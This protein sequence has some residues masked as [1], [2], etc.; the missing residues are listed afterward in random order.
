MDK[1]VK[2]YYK[3]YA[4]YDNYAS[5]PCNIDGLKPVERRIL[6]ASLKVASAK[7]TKSAK[8]DGYTIGNYHPH[9]SCYTTIVEM[10]NQGFFHKQGEFGLNIGVEKTAPAAMR[11][12]E[13]KLKKWIK[14]FCFKYKDM[15]QWKKNELEE[16]E[17][18]YLPVPIPMCF[19]GKNLTYGIGTGY[20]TLIPAFKIN[21]LIQRLKWL[22]DKN[23][24]KKNEPIIKPR[25]DCEVVSSKKDLKKLL[26]TGE[27]RLSLKGKYSKFPS[28]NSIVIYSYPTGKKFQSIYQSYFSEEIKNNNISFLDLSSDGQTK[29]EISVTKTRNKSEIFKN[30]VSKMDDMLS[31][32]INFKI[33]VNDYETKKPVVQSVDEMLLNTYLTFKK[34]NEKMLNM[35]IQKIDESIE[36]LNK[37]ALIRPSLSEVLKKDWDLEKS[38]KYIAKKHKLEFDEVSSIINRYRIAKLLTL[39]TDTDELE[40]TKQQYFENLKNIDKFVWDQYEEIENNE[41]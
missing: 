17:P 16:F 10:V 9:G 19:I 40:K 22:L 28:K 15:V 41:T 29:I 34:I 18:D 12:T 33:V 5:L 20:R 27:S 36:F 21:D 24:K 35:E 26:E 25:F 23:K 30:I 38:I 32:G 37:L 3:N 8:V 13:I 6:L 11:Y 1:I 39:K 14:D 4:V 2:R 7:L 31:G